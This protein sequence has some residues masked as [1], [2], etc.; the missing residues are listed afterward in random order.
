MLFVSSASITNIFAASY[1]AR[2]KATKFKIHMNNNTL[3]YTRFHFIWDRQNNSM[4]CDFNFYYIPCINN[5]DL[6]P[7]YKSTSNA[8]LQ[9]QPCFSNKNERFV[10]ME[11]I[12]TFKSPL[13]HQWRT[14]STPFIKTHNSICSDEGLT[15]QTPA[16]FSLHSPHLS[17]PQ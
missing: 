2:I 1:Q 7:I 14:P 6:R 10:S 13:F 3:Y 11:R 5:C 16:S 8:L 9:T 4:L 17:L 15:A 12:H